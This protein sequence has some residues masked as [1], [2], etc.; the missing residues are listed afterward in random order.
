[1]DELGSQTRPQPQSLQ[2]RVDLNENL[3]EKINGFFVHLQDAP[4]FNFLWKI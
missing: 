3:T 4:V 1:L 2:K